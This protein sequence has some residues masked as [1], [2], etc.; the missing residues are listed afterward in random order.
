VACW[1]AD[2]A[3]LEIELQIQHES[4][5]ACQPIPTGTGFCFLVDAPGVRPKFFVWR[6]LAITSLQ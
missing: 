3:T 1:F 2:F 5:E 4:E 6:F